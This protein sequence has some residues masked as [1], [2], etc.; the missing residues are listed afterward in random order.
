MKNNG[1]KEAVSGLLAKAGI[2]LNGK[3]PYD[4]QVHD[5][6]FY[7][8]LL[9]KGSLGL[10]ESYMDGWWDCEQLDELF[11]R[12]L[13]A[14]LDSKASLTFPVVKEAVLASLMNMQSKARAFEVGE[15]HYD[16]GN[17]LYDAMLD[18]RLIYTCAYW[19]D[20]KDLDAA[21][22]AKLDLVCKKLDLKP[23]Q[24][25]LDI[26]CGWGGM[27]KFAAERY[28]VSGVG[29]T[30]S[31]EQVALARERCK[32][33]PI[34]IRLQDYRELNEKFDHIISLGMFEYVGY[35]NYKTYM[36]VAERCLK[37]GGQEY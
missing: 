28:G 3:N 31:K 27:L 22:E 29:V 1:A 8:R 11:T 15:K 12:V 23:G 36:K 20:A 35:K 10:G 24:R 13:R 7:R 25:I 34:E 2:A 5:E 14:K 16:I 30:V 9:A 19:K 32:G 18:K 37:D 6:R 17:D 21:Q 4:I 26:G 33:L